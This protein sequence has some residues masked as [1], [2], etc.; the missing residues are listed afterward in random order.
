[1]HSYQISCIL[2]IES[3]VRTYYDF[4]V[5]RTVLKEILTLAVVSNLQH[6]E[7]GLWQLNLQLKWLIQW[8]VF[9]PHVESCK[10]FYSVFEAL[11]KCRKTFCFNCLFF[12]W[13]ADVFFVSEL[14]KTFFFSAYPSPWYPHHPTLPHRRCFDTPTP[15]P[16]PILGKRGTFIEDTE[17]FLAARYISVISI[18]D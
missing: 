11:V 1:M 16:L 14:R 5:H 4:L 9:S 2:Q 10:L 3:N 15:L 12:L 13:E 6:F 18:Y 7:V 17:R 8:S